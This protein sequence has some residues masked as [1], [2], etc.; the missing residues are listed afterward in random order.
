MISQINDYTI[1]E[2]LSQGGFIRVY[3][4]ESVD[5]QKYAIKLI[6]INKDNKED[7]KKEV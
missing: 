4:V 7:A 6:P 5:K 2:E 1:I 3:L